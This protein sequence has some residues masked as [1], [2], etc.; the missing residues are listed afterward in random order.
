MDASAAEGVPISLLQTWAAHDPLPEATP[1]LTTFH[2]DQFLLDLPVEKLTKPIE[3]VNMVNF[4]VDFEGRKP[5]S[6]FDLDRCR[7]LGGAL[8]C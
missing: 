6:V 7:Y 5:R 2:S 8:V 4:V 3:G 1:L